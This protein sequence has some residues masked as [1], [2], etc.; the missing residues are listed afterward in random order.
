MIC[1]VYLVNVEVMFFLE[2]HCRG[3]D[4]YN[5]VGGK[6]EVIPMA[7]IGIDLFDHGGAETKGQVSKVGP[8]L[9]PASIPL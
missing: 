9:T 7:K 5:G 4:V 1:D 2:L 8:N 6:D 3:R